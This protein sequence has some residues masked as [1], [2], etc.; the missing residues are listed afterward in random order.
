MNKTEI[1]SDIK[2]AETLSDYEAVEVLWVALIKIANLID[3]TNE[4]ERVLRLVDLIPEEEI[5]QTINLD[6][7]KTLIFLDP[8]LETVLASQHERLESER[9]E[10]AIGQVRSLRQSDPR[11]ALK[12]LGGVLKS[13]RN[14]RGEPIGGQVLN[15]DI[16]KKCFY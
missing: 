15:C 1:I 13:I 11:A 5:E 16:L 10:K 7:V 14:K 6:S 8:P 3:G 4:K 12:N 2:K 9:I